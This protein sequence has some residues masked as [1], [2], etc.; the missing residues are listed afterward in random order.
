MGARSHKEQE[1]LAHYGAQVGS[2]GVANP[3]YDPSLRGVSDGERQGPYGDPAH[4]VYTRGRRSASVISQQ[5]FAPG[6]G[7]G[8]TQVGGPSA[9]RRPEVAVRPEV[10]VH[11]DMEAVQAQA[12]Q[13]QEIPPTYDSIPSTERR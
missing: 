6:P 7:Y 8:P 2:M 5:S 12:M 3:G 13:A 4:Q 1:A 9:E 10:V 11:Q